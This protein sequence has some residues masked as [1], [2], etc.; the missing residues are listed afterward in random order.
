M[1]RSFERVLSR[2]EPAGRL[3][4]LPRLAGD[5]RF[6]TGAS[7]LAA[8]VVLAFGLVITTQALG[9]LRL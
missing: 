9:A 1:R 3:E 8:C 6:A 4:R 7:L 5:G 2:A